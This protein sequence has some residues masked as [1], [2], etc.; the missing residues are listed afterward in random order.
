MVG[1]LYKAFV[2]LLFLL[3]IFR[4]FYLQ[5]LKGGLYYEMSVNNYLRVIPLPGYRGCILDRYGRELATNKLSFC[6][7]VLPDRLKDKDKVFELL[8]EE[9]GIRRAQ[10]EEIY[11]TNYRAPFYPVKLIEDI[12]KGRAIILKQKFN[13]VAGVKIVE[14]IKRYYP[15]GPLCAHVLG[16][17]GEPSRKELEELKPYGYRYS[18]LIGKSG[19]EKSF[20]P[21]LRG[22]DGGM[23]VKVDNKG[24]VIEV[25]SEEKPGKGLDVYLTIDLNL[26]KKAEELLGGE[27]GCFIVMDVRSGELLVLASSPGFDPNIFLGGDIEVINAILKSEDKPLLNRAIQGEYP[28]GS[29]FKLIVAIAGLEEGKLFKWN[30]FFCPG[31]YELKGK[32]YRCWKE[33]GH[34]WE[35]L[36][37]AIVHSCNVFFYQASLKV[38]AGQIIKYAGLF[39]FG[40]RTG[41]QLPYERCGLLPTPEWKRKAL[42]QI[43]Y[44]GDTVNLSIGQGYLL[45]T[46]LQV[47]RFMAAIA[48]GGYLMKPLICKAID[49]IGCERQRPRKLAISAETLRFL[50]SALKDVVDDPT[51]TGQLAK[52][53]ALKVAGKTATA[54]N[55][56]GA[57]HAWF[58]GFAPYK[59]PEIAFVA[60]VENGGGGGFITAQIVREF[61]KYYFKYKRGDEG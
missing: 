3:L 1:R 35:S 22:S 60:M 45:V 38:G 8:E 46:P 14:E 32:R 50:R 19:I 20:E 57:P 25:L 23:L 47:V 11:R 12:D 56:H 41:I 27:R 55:P 43:W 39:G 6:L 29:I 18:S 17:L 24:R 5:V 51:G 15:Q 59:R 58:A 61:L 53:D 54:E 16:Y 26:Q 2:T 4:L 37:E 49:G 30:R 13:G 28:V 7:E 21:Y 36:K 33:N 31:F 34:G 52:L 44:P 42:R 10:L 40:K 9:F 48:N